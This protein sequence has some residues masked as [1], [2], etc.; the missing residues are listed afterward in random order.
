MTSFFASCAKG[1]EEMLGQELEGLGASQTKLTIAGVHF[2]ATWEDV[3]AML[4]NTRLASR[5]LHPLAEMDALNPDE[6]YKNMRRIVW[7]EHMTVD[8]TFAINASVNRS[9]IK[10][11]KYAA[12]RTK[13][14][15][16]DHFRESLDIRP[17]VDRDDPDLRFHVT[18]REN[19][20]TLS[21][22]LC[23]APLH[24]RGY[25]RAHG[26]APLKE[27][28]AAAVLIRAG[29]PNRIGEGVTLVD[30]MC[31]SGTFLIEGL[32]MAGKIAPGLFRD[33]FAVQNW[34]KFD[35]VAWDKALGAAKAQREAGLARLGDMQIRAAG[36]DLDKEVL[37]L[38]EMAVTRAGLN[39]LVQLGQRDL[40]HWKP[41]NVRGWRHGGLVI[42]NPPYGE[43]LGD[44]A[45]IPK[46]Y[47][48]LGK[49]L[50]ECFKGF[51]A[52]VFTGNPE[53]GKRMGIRAHK[54]YKLYNGALA[55]DVLNF[56]LEAGSFLKHAG[57]GPSEA[58]AAFANRL[59]KNLK[60]RR[61]WAKKQGFEAYRVYDADIPEYNVAV[62]LYKDMVVVSEY[63]PPSEINPAKTERRLNDVMQ[64]L[65]EVLGVP[66]E[67]ISLKKRRRRK[68]GDTYDRI[69][70]RR[71][72]FFVQEGDMRFEVNIWDYL[73]TG[74]FND[75]R[76]VRAMIR[77]E[78]EGKRFLNLFAYTGAVTVAA[79]KGGAKSTTTIDLSH[80]YLDWAQRNLGANGFR[81][82]REHKLVRG[83]CCQWLKEAEG[84]FDLIFIDPP[85][86][87]NSKSFMGSFDVQ[88]DHVW[89]LQTAS[90][91]LAPGGK[92]IFSNNFRKFKLDRESLETGGLVIEDIT[93]AT[94]PEDYARR[95]NI[96][97][98]FTLQK[99]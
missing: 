26:R 78:A 72:F 66:A 10:H 93:S 40:K 41:A 23:G 47:Q 7:H 20:A 94:I 37:N 75:H 8:D 64:T 96:H 13:D 90:N 11:D 62:D 85:T 68:D 67:H 74:L 44:E 87:S 71:E 25:R 18:I 24:E 55:C 54:R 86:F 2:E 57:D 59:R 88:R 83:D 80:T 61:K 31:G 76:P 99:A 91:F 38:A 65:P 5:I 97:H 30:P 63:A 51:H 49:I 6:L 15:I 9:E 92:L 81:E 39:D 60:Q 4:L 1:L 73:D 77:A 36:F 43:R 17:D 79:A 53:M 45:E 70:K 19:R 21:L 14:A 42:V 50:K 58:A 22:D 34:L 46:L 98:C 48:T 3:Y 69:E 82:G 95:G 56:Q 29:W 33:S 89:L 35:A 16:V 84:E 32:L 28:L 27:N 52:S 12:L